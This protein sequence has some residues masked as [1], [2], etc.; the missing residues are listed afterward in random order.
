MSSF[1]KRT[2]KGTGKTTPGN[3]GPELVRDQETH[4]VELPT[5]KAQIPGQ[6][7]RRKAVH[8]GFWVV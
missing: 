6:T 8:E 4:A 5:L 1:N 2:E 7:E 3:G